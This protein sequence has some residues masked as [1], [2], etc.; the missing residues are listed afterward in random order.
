MDTKSSGIAVAAGI[1]SVL[2]V[3]SALHAGAAAVPL[4]IFAALP[5]YICA[6]AWGTYAAAV[7]SVTAI[8][9]S[10]FAIAPQAAIVIGLGLT[11]PASVTG[12]QANLAQETDNGMEWY[13]LSRLLF[14]LALVLSISILMIG[15]AMDFG[16]YENH[17]DIM[18]AIQEY[19]T[20][21]PPPTPLTDEQISEIAAFVFR[22]LPFMFAS[23]W[24]ILHVVNL[25]VAAII[26]RMSGIM[27]RPKDDIPASIYMPRSGIAVLA[28]GIL[29][30][31]LLSGMLHW[32]AIVLSGTF[33]TAFA[34]VGLA[35]VHL[36]SR[37]APVYLVFLIVSYIF[38]AMFYLP[39]FMFAIGGI[40]RTFYKSTSTPPSAGSNLS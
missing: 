1:A 25:Q 17:P 38:I 2:A 26:C 19:F 32:V 3:Y 39:L 16:T 15:Y 21:F 13:P 10:A 35:T 36:R 33:L 40:F 29:G 22:W 5:V 7:A 23:I 30:M 4:L 18:R 20:K 31:L 34:L 37:T 8:I 11:I 24:L 9:A 14:N 28:G 12:H 6:L 27:P